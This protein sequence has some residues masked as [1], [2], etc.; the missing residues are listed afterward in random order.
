MTSDSTTHFDGSR[1]DGGLLVRHRMPVYVA[2]L[3]LATTLAFAG[4]ALTS[5]ST[6][7]IAASQAST[8]PGAQDDRP[9][10]LPDR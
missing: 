5:R 4:R 3:L 6:S 1:Q 9:L 7:T 2:L 8:A 10:L